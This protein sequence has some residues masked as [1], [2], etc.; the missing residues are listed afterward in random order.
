MT[1]CGSKRSHENIIPSSES[2][3]NLRIYIV[4]VGDFIC[5]NKAQNHLITSRTKVRIST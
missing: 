2:K 5:K 1:A 4:N 3:V